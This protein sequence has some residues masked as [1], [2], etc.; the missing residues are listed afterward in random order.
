MDTVGVVAESNGDGQAPGGTARGT[1]A[2]NWQ[3]GEDR[4]KEGNAQEVARGGEVD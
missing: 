1:P 2:T 4:G 3:G